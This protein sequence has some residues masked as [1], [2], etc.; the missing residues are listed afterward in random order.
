MTE[1]DRKRGERLC[2]RKSDRVYWVL[3]EL[4]RAY[5]NLASQGNIGGNNKL[6]DYGCGNM[7]YRPL[8]EKSGFHYSGFD[9][10]GN[11]KADGIISPDGRLMAGD[12]SFHFLL[13]SQVLEHV[14]DPSLY[15]KEAWRVLIPNGKL[16]LSTHGVWKY[17]PDP[18]DFWRWT[19]DGL[20]KIIADNGFEMVRFEGIV[21]PAATGIQIFQDAWYGR[22][23]QPLRT[24]FIRLCQVA[25]QF[26][27]KR[28]TQEVKA[29]DACVYL[30]EA[31][32]KC[33]Q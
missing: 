33:P 7:P 32:K 4:R 8:F 18:T 2:P 13:S 31:V 9:F 25:M 26:C 21:G 12:N 5:E 11:D 29:N 10:P 24:L 15:L 16:L 3:S 1:E 27:D 20:R 19:G 23:P 22:L 6:I 30:L 28:C 17:H 14:V